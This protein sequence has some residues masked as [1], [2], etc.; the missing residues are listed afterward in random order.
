MRGQVKQDKVRRGQ[1]KRGQV[2]Q[3]KVRQNDL[4]LAKAMSLASTRPSRLSRIRQS[5]STEADQRVMISIQ[6]SI[7]AVSC[8][9][10]ASGSLA[11]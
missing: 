11:K 7:S 5:R 2:K 4:V 1:V 8:F 9:S 3:D 6:S 10:I